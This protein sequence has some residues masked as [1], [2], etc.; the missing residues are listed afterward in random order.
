MFEVQEWS[1]HVN[2]FLLAICIVDAWK[3]Y[4]GAKSD[5]CKMCR[6]LRPRVAGRRQSDA[7]SDA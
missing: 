2:T 6:A 1:M 5:G 3:L 4:A 7:R